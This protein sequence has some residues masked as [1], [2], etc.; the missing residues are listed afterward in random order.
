LLLSAIGIYGVTAYSAARRAREV[1]IRMALG[2]DP[3]SVLRMFAWH[4]LRVALAGGLA[5]LLAA[6]AVSRLAQSLLLGVGALDALAFGAATAGLT[7]VASTASYLA[8]RAD[9]LGRSAEQA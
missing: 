3:R 1:G 9:G 5:G 4:G 7:V 6:A 2:A 8:A